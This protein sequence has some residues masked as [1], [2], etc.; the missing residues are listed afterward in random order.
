MS[1]DSLWTWFCIS[2]MPLV[3]A[4]MVM[5]SFK[6]ELCPLQAPISHRER[7]TVVS[8]PLVDQ[9]QAMGEPK[10]MVFMA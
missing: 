1:Q 5:S 4:V 8:I 7:R 10:V 6:C 3:S 9:A 2:M